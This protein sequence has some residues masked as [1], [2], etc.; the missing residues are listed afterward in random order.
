MR[1]INYR[2][3]D[4]WSL[5][6]DHEIFFKESLNSCREKFDYRCKTMPHSRLG[7]LQSLIISGKKLTKK[8]GG[9]SPHLVCQKMTKIVMFRL[10]HSSDWPGYPSRLGSLAG[11]QTNLV[12]GAR[13]SSDCE[14]PVAGVPEL[15][16]GE[17]HCEDC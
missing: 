5:L 6:R 15:S 8:M 3:D 17:D 2:Y 14:C 9:R 4:K 13:D 7:P 16:G 1:A 11:G 12:Q 10:G